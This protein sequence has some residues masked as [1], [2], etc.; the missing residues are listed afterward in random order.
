MFWPDLRDGPPLDPRPFNLPPATRVSVE[1]GQFLIDKRA[2]WRPLQIAWWLNDHSDWS[3]LH[4][5]GDK[6]TLEVG[7]AWCG[8]PS[9]MYSED[10]AWSVHSFLQAGP[11]GEVLFVHRCKDKFRF[12]SPTYMN[13]QPFAAKARWWLACAHPNPPL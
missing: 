4:G 12:G 2:S 11:D 10:V 5:Y 13:P 9:A 7:W 6:H 1:S 8:A 3:Y